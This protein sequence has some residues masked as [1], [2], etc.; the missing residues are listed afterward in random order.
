MEE[1]FSQKNFSL[2]RRFPKRRGASPLAWSFIWRP[3]LG[4]RGF[5]IENQNGMDSYIFKR[6]K[7]RHLM[8]LKILPRENQ[9]GTHLRWREEVNRHTTLGTQTSLKM[10]GISWD[11]LLGKNPRSH[12]LLKPRDNY[13]TS[14]LMVL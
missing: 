14:H 2:G 11:Y 1:S 7:E 8:A 13:E 5:T 6:D 4:S 12:G 9:R 3:T 10:C